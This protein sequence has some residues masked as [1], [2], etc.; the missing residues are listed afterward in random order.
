VVARVILPKVGNSVWILQGRQVPH[1]I[2]LVGCVLRAGQSLIDDIRDA[3]QGVVL[4][5][6]SHPGPNQ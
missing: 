6:L 5:P 2:I 3:V 4:K 1:R